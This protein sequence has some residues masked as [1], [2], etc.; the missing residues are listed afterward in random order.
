MVA[1][2]PV[3]HRFNRYSPCEM[4]SSVAVLSELE[5]GVC[6]RGGAGGEEEEEEDVVVPLSDSSGLQE[7][8]S[9][10]VTAPMPPL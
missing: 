1:T 9:E 8:E 6:L 3:S 10:R 2:W 5:R 7:T 4:P